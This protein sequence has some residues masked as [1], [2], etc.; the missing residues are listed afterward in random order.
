ML[1]S[2]I[3]FVFTLYL[4]LLFIPLSTAQP[5]MDDGESYTVQPGDWL[6]TIAEEYMVTRWPT[7]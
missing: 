6:S 1:K 5:P 2:T 3:R 4:F 7:P